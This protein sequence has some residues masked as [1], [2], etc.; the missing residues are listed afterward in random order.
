MAAIKSGKVSCMES[1]C[2][3]VVHNVH[4]QADVTFWKPALEM[5]KR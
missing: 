1:G 4:E 2:H 3:D 5:V